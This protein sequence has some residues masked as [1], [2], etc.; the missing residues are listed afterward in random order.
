MFLTAN[1]GIEISHQNIYFL[2][3]AVACTVHPESHKILS[4]AHLRP[5]LVC[6]QQL[7][8]YWKGWLLVLQKAN[9]QN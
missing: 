8:L 9:D 5:L 2:W 6:M 7:G 1:F 4:S 3:F